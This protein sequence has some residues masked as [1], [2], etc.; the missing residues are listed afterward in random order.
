[1]ESQGYVPFEIIIQKSTIVRYHG[2]HEAAVAQPIEQEPTV[3][4][5]ETINA[6]EGKICK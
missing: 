5:F 6:V 4:T 3:V 2:M 1:M